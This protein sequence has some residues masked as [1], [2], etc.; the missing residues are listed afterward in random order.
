MITLG[1]VVQHNDI[2][3]LA[4]N[5]NGNPG[6]VATQNI[7]IVAFATPHHITAVIYAANQGIVAIF[8]I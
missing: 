4:S 6:I 1:A 5:L 2:V 8:A 7:D 3:T